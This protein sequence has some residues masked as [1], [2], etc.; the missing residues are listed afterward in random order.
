MLFILTFIWSAFTYCITNSE[1]CWYNWT[2]IVDLFPSL[3]LLIPKAW[4]RV[5]CETMSFNSNSV[6]LSSMKLM[7]E[8]IVTTIQ[9]SCVRLQHRNELPQ[10]FR[11]NRLIH[12]SDYHS[13]CNSAVLCLSTR[14]CF[15]SLLTTQ[16]KYFY[17]SPIYWKKTKF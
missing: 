16:T 7:L 3:R 11:A 10:L 17:Q 4:D 9:G 14:G 5:S 6:Y 8:K 1:F 12:G 13:V 2:F 15:I